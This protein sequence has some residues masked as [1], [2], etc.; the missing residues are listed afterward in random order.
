MRQLLF[1]PLTLII[2]SWFCINAPLLLGFRVLPGDAVNEFYPMVRFNVDTLRS[3]EMPWWNPYI[4]SGYPQAADPQAML[5]SPLIT[6]WMLLIDRPGTTWFVWSVLLHVLL[7]ALSFAAFLKRLKVT[8]VGVVVGALVF[9]AGGVAAS[10]LQHVPI[11]VVYGFLALT[12]LSLVRFMERP[13]MVRG[14][15][16]G[17]SAAGMVV[18]PVQ[19]TYLAFWMLL[20]LVAGGV[21]KA[22]PRLNV[23]Q[24]WV[25]SAAL[26]TAGVVC[27]ALSL[28]QILLT[29]AFLAVS[30]RPTLD[31]AVA[32]DMSVGPAS[33]LTL[34]LPN[35]LQSLRGT[36]WG[37]VDR[38]ETFLYIGALPLAIL[39]VEWRHLVS[40][41]VR[42]TWC[43]YFVGLLVMSAIYA[44]GSHTPIYRFLYEYVPGV[45]L[46]RRPSDALYLAN[47]ALAALAAVAV[48]SP[49]LTSQVCLRNALVVSLLLAMA[50]TASMR[51]DGEDWFVPSIL[52]PVT[53]V[54]GCAWLLRTDHPRSLAAVCAICL[55]IDYR[56]FNVNGEFN[57]F[58]N[59]PEKYGK[60]G[61]VRFLVNESRAAD[62]ATPVRVEVNGLGAVWKNMGSVYGIHG[63]Q[64]YG[65]LRWA[66]Y[67]R[68][69]GAYGDG[70]GPRPS[71]PVN[72]SIDSPMNRLLGVRYVV[73]ESTGIEATDPSV[74]YSDAK[75]SVQRMEMP[76]PRVLTP[77]RGSVVDP[78][79]LSRVMSHFDTMDFSEALIL[80]ARRPGEDEAIARAARICQGRSKVRT[81]RWGNNEQL[82]SVESSAPAWV[83]VSELDFPGWVATVDGEEAQHFRANGLFRAICMPAGQHHLRFSLDPIA[84]IREA[85]LRPAAWR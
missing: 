16:L 62:G 10:R 15:V 49:R 74:I 28:P 56:C 22:W 57:H 64:G 38:I 26:L 51:G 54:A 61:A 68:W 67:D 12:M 75:A 45:N 50:G 44:A 11:V 41:A 58:R 30:N 39:L 3:G 76:Y 66:L 18:Q 71:T 24:R 6:L 79:D 43:R 48:S 5:F 34:F 19:L 59:T 29:S 9:M 23:R 46:F 80:T 73:S 65:P 63:T 20:S 81:A 25:S 14:L 27:T 78:S 83:V 33:A 77:F 1:R 82:L 84:M 35:A 47:V 8:D 40:Q 4:F 53:L 69:Y 60:E 32:L 13:S 7:G 55:V 31:V 21:Y 42:S 85:M 70:N 52:L 17:S 36:Y 72:A 37:S 2:I